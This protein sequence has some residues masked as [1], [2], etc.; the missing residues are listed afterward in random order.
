MPY[1]NLTSLLAEIRNSTEAHV[2]GL[3][4]VTAD[5]LGLDSRCGRVWVDTDYNVVCDTCY[6]VA[7]KG[8]RIEYYGGFEYIE[9]EHRDEFGD[10]V[11]YYATSDRVQDCLEHLME[12]DGECTSES[13]RG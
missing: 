2:Q 4:E 10:Y 9:D 7:H 5:Q 12:A 11:V 6:I 3:R 13:D 8:S 1:S